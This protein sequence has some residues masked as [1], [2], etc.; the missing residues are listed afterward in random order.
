MKITEFRKVGFSSGSAPAIAKLKRWID[1]AR[2]PGEKFGS[3]YFVWIDKH[4]NLRWPPGK[5][6]ISELQAST[7]NSLADALIPAP[8]GTK[9]NSADLRSV[10]E[11]RL[12][13]VEA[14]GNY[15]PGMVTSE[16]NPAISTVIDEFESS[17]LRDQNYS[18]SSWWGQVLC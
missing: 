10:T 8:L 7:E 3:M 9:M 18:A 16:D 13:P 15:Q 12:F 4:L 1:R 11:S 2:I 14:L 17:W 6:S 5:T